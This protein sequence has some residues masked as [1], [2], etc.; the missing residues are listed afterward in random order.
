MEW[1]LSFAKV[2]MV[3][4]SMGLR[5]A[6]AYRKIERPY[7]RVAVKVPD[8]NYIGA[9]PAVRIRRFVQGELKDEY[10]TAYYLVAE[11]RLQVRDNAIEAARL[12]IIRYLEKKIQKRFWLRVRAY[13]HHVL[14]ENKQLTGAGADRLQKGMRHAFGRPSGRAAQVYP[15]KVMFEVVTLKS[16]EPY[17]RE[18]FRRAS[19]KMPGH[20]KI[21]IEPRKVK[22]AATV[23]QSS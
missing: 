15:G 5:P 20:Y 2:F 7:T 4:D 16:F 13:P 11:D 19:M 9:N 3:G 8:K 6:R 18:A 22:E 21:V 14:R 23:S 10:D 1:F 12:A 17:V